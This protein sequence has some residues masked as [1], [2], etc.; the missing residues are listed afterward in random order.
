MPKGRRESGHFQ[1]EGA[2]L[3]REALAA[4]VQLNVGY[5]CPERIRGKRDEKLAAELSKRF[6]VF[7]VTERVLKAMTNT[8]SP[9]PFAAEAPVPKLGLDDI[10]LPD[11]CLVA[12]AAGTQDPGNLGS[13]IRTAHA[14]GATGLVVLGNTVDPYSPKVVRA[15][16]G[17]LFSVTVVV[18]REYDEFL[19]WCRERDVTVVGATVGSDELLFDAEFPPRMAALLGSETQGLPDE[20]ENADI[21]KI[22]IP[23]PG[24]AESLNVSV[25]AGVVMYEYRRQFP[26]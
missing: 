18:R 15:T 24:G 12:V 16:M 2:S 9:Q 5:I 23:M 21:R 8:V 1:L 6:D 14:V 22:R 17:S 4:D 11:Q 25:A 20:L 7:E 13:M 19:A 10:E 3:I 26:I